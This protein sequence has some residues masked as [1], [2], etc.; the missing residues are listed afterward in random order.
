[1]GSEEVMMEKTRTGISNF[2]VSIF[3]VSFCLITSAEA[4]MFI[5]DYSVAKES[6]LRSIPVAAIESAKNNLHILYCGTSHSSQVVDGM[7]GLM[8]YKTGDDTL[9]SVTFGGNPIPGSLDIHY[10]GASGTDLSHDSVDGNGHTG[11]FHG[12]VSY[13]DSHPDVNVV[14]WSWCSIEGHDVTIYINNF[15]E[16]IDMYKAGGSKGRTAANEVT[17]VFMTGYARGGDGETAEPPYIESPYQNYQRIVDYC[18]AN[19]YFCLDYWSQDVCEYETDFYKPTES[20][21]DNIQHKAYF[22]THQEG[23]HWFA[24]RSYSTG[25]VKWPAHCDGT[26]QHITSN[27]RAYAAWWIMARIA[28]WNPDGELVA[29]FSSNPT[30]GT[31]PL[32]VSFTDTSTGE[33][34]GWSWDFDNNGTEDSSDQNPTHTYNDAGTYSVALEVTVAGGTDTETKT[35]YIT[36]TAPIQYNLTVNTVGSGSVTLDPAGGIYDPGTEVQ[37][38]PVPGPGWAFNGWSGDLSGYSNPDTIVMNS[39][40][41]ITATFDLDDDAD[42]ISDAEEDAGPNGGDGNDDNQ[43]D[44]DQANVATFHTQDG[45]NYIT[46]ESAT[47]TTLADC[48]AVSIPGAAGAPSGVTFPYGFIDFTINGAGPGGATTLILYLPA[49]ANI[50][51]YWKYGPTPTNSNPH[52]YEFMYES[53][54]QTDAVINGNKITLYFIDGQRGDDD[55]TGNGI[56]IDQGGAGTYSSSSP[57]DDSSSGG[58]C[59]VRTAYGK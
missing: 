10:R 14:M 33:I 39:D 9:F 34:T 59:F 50:N 30:I 52:W 25:A 53:S 42:G 37:L 49:G 36:V 21:N 27:R 12:T 5:G 45:T 54:T 11:Y 13:L 44:S 40:K 55:I 15:Q 31:A 18:S 51:T 1:M 20:G 28:G 58:G 38:T 46:L 23:V 35:N 6:V 3:L 19:E 22:D 32:E 24:T 47:G 41:T 29:N 48:S 26:P 56:I 8:E 2:I 7:R 16:L 4:E 57:P 43:Q 17:F